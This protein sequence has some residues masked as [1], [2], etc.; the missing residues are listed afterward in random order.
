MLHYLP[1]P[2]YKLAVSGGTMYAWVAYMSYMYDC[3]VYTTLLSLSLSSTS[4][5]F[6]ISRSRPAFYLDQLA[7]VS[8]SSMMM[9]QSY[10]RGWIPFG[11][12]LLGLL[13]GV[14]FFYVGQASRTYAYHPSKAIA[15]PCH[16]LTHVIS[17]TIAIFNLTLFSPSM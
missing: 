11:L 16:I 13:Q 12:S 15:L 5:W 17:S 8:W 1:D 10:I 6:H 2:I 3:S 9:Y 14:L 7:V 4:M